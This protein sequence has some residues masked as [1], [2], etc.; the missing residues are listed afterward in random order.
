MGRKSFLIVA[1]TA[2][3]ILAMSGYAMASG[4]TDIK[5]HWAELQINEWAN[6]GL[7]GGYDDGTFRPNSEVSRAEFVSLVNRAFNL[8]NQD[9]ADAG[10][11]DVKT[12]K[13]Y[14][15]DVNIAKAA[16]YIGGY[17]DGTFKPEQT[18]TRQEVASILVRLSGLEQTT[19]GLGQFA[20][21]STFAAWSR[22]SI[23]AVT[24][25]KLMGGFPDKTFKPANSITRAETVVTLDRALDKDDGDKVTT[26]SAIEGKV[27]FNDKAVEG[28]EVHVFKAGSF[29]VLGETKTDKDGKYKV[30]LDAG[31]YDI[32]AS[33]DQQ[34]AYIDSVK[35]TNNQISTADLKLVKAAV[36]KGKLLDKNDRAVKNATI[37]F[38]TNPTFV[39][40]TGSRGEYTIAVLPDRTYTV[41]A[42][43][44]KKPAQGPEI[45]K[46][47]MQV[48][49]AGEHAIK[50]L[51]APFSVSSAGGGGGGGGGGGSIDDDNDDDDNDPGGPTTVKIKSISISPDADRL[52][53]GVGEQESLK[54]ILNPSNTTQTGVDWTVISGQDKVSLNKNK[55]TATVEG[56]A[57]GD[58]LVKVVSTANSSIQ[59]TIDI[60]VVKVQEVDVTPGTPKDLDESSEPVKVKTKVTLG[61]KEIPLAVVLP[62]VQAGTTM[63]IEEVPTDADPGDDLLAFVGLNLTISTPGVEVTVELPVPDGLTVDDAGAFH[64]NGAVWEYREA[65]IINGKLVFT[66]QLSPVA[67]SKKMP[68]PKDLKATVDGSSVNLSWTAAPKG[69]S[70]D[71]ITVSYDV[72]RDN[73]KIA[74]AI[75]ATT[76]TDADL[77]SGEYTYYVK[78]Y[79]NVEAGNSGNVIKFE[80]AP[81]DSVTAVV[82]TGAGAPK[83]NKFAGI[84]PD[85]EN[86]I[87]V[88]LKEINTQTSI[89]VSQDCTLK[90]TL[91]GLD[92]Y[93]EF[94]LK[95]GSNDISNIL[96]PNVNISTEDLTT[97]FKALKKIDSATVNSIIADIDFSGLFNTI[98]EASDQTKGSVLTASNFTNAF[99][100]AK[101]APAGYKSS[102]LNDMKTI[103]PMVINSENK[104]TIIKA[105]KSE[106]LLSV[107]EDKEALWEAILN[108]DISGIDFSGIFNSITNADDITQ[109]AIIEAI[110]FKTLFDEINKL[111]AETRSEI[112]E[113][114]NFT[115]LF[116]AIKE[117]TDTEAKQAFIT[118]DVP[119]MIATIASDNQIDRLELIKSLNLNQVKIESLFDWLKTIGGNPDV[120]ALTAEV[121]N[122]N[123]A[124]TYNITIA[125]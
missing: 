64:Y 80:S 51:N 81:S 54:A 63:T 45:L 10:F 68:A 56:S 32:T 18:I 120:V 97:L 50:T 74:S 27:T 12:G 44:P 67:V 66:T 101:S 37:L 61:G 33:T 71:K 103:I 21:S 1:L 16:G 73:T 79:R 111:D 92:S 25:A 42:F 105:I 116:N 108:D 117:S 94:T 84:A 19:D 109:N 20:D 98:N 53:I 107:L 99:K 15:K 112:F 29:E 57:P 34:V 40:V 69:S 121:S 31:D 77:E 118:E 90:L 78:A 6:D 87:D 89:E 43:N 3:L 60:Q 7:A 4:F 96:V 123:G 9:T 24:Q 59:D 28:A 91:V 100:A 5:G 26:E 86:S 82:G 75:V 30:V 125:K 58:A 46:E 70:N 110:D 13:W 106:A 95:S 114:I 22:G 35:I 47:N 2:C 88:P 8:G 113:A 49:T 72:F 11:N 119:N 85:N 55:T 52:T 38:T 23:G 39:S 41:R 104:T 48:D 102:L 62:N 93:G 36:L 124:T 65:T 122:N 83:I 14:Y 17:T 115:T 76:Y